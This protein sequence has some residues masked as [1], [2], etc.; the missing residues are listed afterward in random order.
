MTSEENPLVKSVV[1]QYE[2]SASDEKMIE[3][4]DKRDIS[5]MGEMMAGQ[6]G[7]ILQAQK[8]LQGKIKTGQQVD[9][10]L[11]ELSHMDI[12]ILEDQNMIIII[13]LLQWV[14]NR[15]LRG[16]VGFQ[17]DNL[18]MRLRKTLM[19]R[20]HGEKGR[21]YEHPHD[22]SVHEDLLND[23]LGLANDLVKMFP[24]QSDLIEIRRKIDEQLA[25]Y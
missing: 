13:Q 14:Q 3:K 10:F 1:Q 8:M 12:K 22:R 21:H 24:D 6:R 18:L 20:M 5:G 16:V 17:V 15:P 23:A 2:I 9:E 7:D 4:L 25:R 11:R 19:Y